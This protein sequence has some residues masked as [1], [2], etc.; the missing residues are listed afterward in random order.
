V[1]PDEDEPEAQAVAE[2]FSD[3]NRSAAAIAPQLPGAHSTRVSECP[4]ASGPD[5]PGRCRPAGRSCSEEVREL[6]VLK[7]TSKTSVTIDEESPYKAAREPKFVQ[8]PE[9]SFLMT[10]GHGDPNTSPEYRDAIGALY[11]MSYGLKFAL[12]KEIGLQYRVGPLEGLFWAKKMAGMGDR[13]ADWSWTMMIAQPD[14]VTP[15]RF[16]TMRDEVKRKKGLPGLERM[17]LERFDEGLCVQILHIGPYSAEGPDIERLHEFIHSQGCT[18]EGRK[19]KHHEIYMS[20]PRRAVAAKWKTIIRQ[21]VE[22]K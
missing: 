21:P 9:M 22:S 5:D 6:Q 16:A 10:D 1:H 17:R 19:Q 12:K 8:V 4:A 13:K 20:D 3:P 11:S 2:A 7:T 15:Q 14:A 18:F